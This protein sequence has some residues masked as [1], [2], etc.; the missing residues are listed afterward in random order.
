MAF[1]VE[2]P[3]PPSLNNAYFN[4]RQGGRVKTK[5][6]KDWC[7]AAGWAIKAGVKAD[8]RVAGA[9]RVSINLPRHMNGDIDNRVKGI[10]DALVTSGRID[11]DRNMEE[12]RVQRRHDGDGALVHVKPFLNPRAAA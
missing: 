3:V 7:A 5:A 10:L 4:R 6:Y 9:F 8:D 2:I 11:D 1:T 12:L